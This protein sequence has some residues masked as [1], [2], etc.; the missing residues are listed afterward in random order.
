MAQITFASNATPSLVN[1]DANFTELYGGVLI[2]SG[3]P[4]GYATGGGGAVTQITGK[5][6]TVVLNKVCGQ[7]TTHNASL[8][9]GATVAFALTNSQIGSADVV[10]V[11]RASVSAG[12]DNAYDIKADRVASG[13]AIVTIKNNTGGALAEALVLNFVIIK[14]ASA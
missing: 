2:A 4:I 11:V 6:T 9:S 8:A 10:I 7:I 12:G 5:S 14:G 3:N 1:L 13:A